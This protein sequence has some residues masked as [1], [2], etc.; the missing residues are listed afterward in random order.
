MTVRVLALV[1]SLRAG[2]HNLQ[3]AEAAVRHAPEGVTV[4]I[5]RGLAD[6]PFYNEDLDVPDAAPAAAAALR[7]AA[8]EADALLLVSP[9]YNG[10]IPAVLKNAIDW[11][12]RPYGAGAI[13]G[14]PVAVVGTALGGYG[15]VWA[16]DEARKSAGIAGGAVLD[17][18]RLSIPSSGTRFAATH[19]ADDAEAV[20]GLRQVLDQLAAKAIEGAEGAADATDAEAVAA[21]A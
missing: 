18:A 13:S 3:L 20:A 7:A 9:E 5:H 12:S 1:G 8:Q 15:G 19:P 14:K 2:S 10:T 17:E 4:E 16:Q 6:V 11:L 21:T